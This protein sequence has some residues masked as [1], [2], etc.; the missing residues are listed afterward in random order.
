MLLISGG[1]SQFRVGSAPYFSDDDS[2]ENEVN[3]AM[4]VLKTR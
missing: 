1:V 3:C 2:F 4:T